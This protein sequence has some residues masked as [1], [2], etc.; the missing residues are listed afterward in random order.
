MTMQIQAPTIHFSY[1]PACSAE[2]ILRQV[3]KAAPV[4]RINLSHQRREE[5]TDI[6]TQLRKLAKEENTP[7]HIACDLRGRKLRTG[8]LGPKQ[9]KLKLET[10][11]KILLRGVPV[12][13]EQPFTNNTISISHPNLHQ[14]LQPGHRV[15]LDDAALDL[16]V[17]SIQGEHIYCVLEH[18][19]FLF[20]RVGCN[21]PDAALDLPA[22]T[23]RDLQDLDLL[24]PLKP[25]ALYLS[26]SESPDDIKMLRMELQA[27]DM[28]AQIIAKIET[29]T[30]LDNLDAIAA[31]ADML[32]LAR[33]DLGVAIPWSQLP[34]IQHKFAATA[35]RQH[36]PWI[37]AGEVAISS[38]QRVQPS[39]AEL[40][41][42][43]LAC[44]QGAA[45]LIL[46]DESATGF[47][48]QETVPLIKKVLA[49]FCVQ[50]S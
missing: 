1:G 3:I 36:K 21:L 39:R 7:L 37:L 38:L 22:L 20:P 27:R 10:G 50:R 34:T 11:Q 28:D 12:D 5:L 4:C 47:A 15:L 18:G 31:E 23:S 42:L 16:R 32:C 14:H 46:S 48:P 49:D 33:G 9:S 13:H 2:A 43:Y 45:G 26:Y 17:K 44:Q 24:A 40:S 30:A 35:R 8:P 29:Q 19:T 41:D 25:D 6:F